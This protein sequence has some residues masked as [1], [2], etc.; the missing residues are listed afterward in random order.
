MKAGY[1]V[2]KAIQKKLRSWSKKSVINWLASKIGTVA[3]KRIVTKAAT[4][5]ASALA[6]YLAANVAWLGCL[7]GPIGGLAA[8]ATGW[9]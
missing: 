1:I 4:A 8:G 3:A 5:S 7:A 6:A 9:L 2:G